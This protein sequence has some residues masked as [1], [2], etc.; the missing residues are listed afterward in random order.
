MASLNVNGVIFA[1]PDTGDEEWG[2][3]ASNWATAVT[4]GMLQKQGGSFTLTAEVDFGSSFG[5]KS[6]YYKSRTSNPGTSGVLRLGNT[7][8]IV[9]RNAANSANLTFGVNSANTLLFDGATIAVDASNVAATQG[10]RIA[11]NDNTD[12]AS[13][14]RLYCLVG[15]S[16]GGD[17][18]I[19]LSVASATDWS[20]GCDNSDSDAIVLN[21]GT[22]PGANDP[23]LRISTAGLVA[24]GATGGTQDHVVNGKL[25]I[26]SA[27]G[28]QI[29]ASS[30]NL[31]I[32]GNCY[33]GSTSGPL[34]IASGTSL[35]V[36]GGFRVGGSSQASAIVEFS[37]TTQGF[38]PPRM[39][40]AQKNAIS[41]PAN[42][43]IV[44][45]S[46][47]DQLFLYNGTWKQVT[48]T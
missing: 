30:T 16:S 4:N 11:N 36:D 9:W 2:S 39:S 35:R 38:L 31:V 42:G 25:R 26:G 43:L 17:P 10:I 27:S 13:N 33:V 8:L 23:F 41:S 44:Y 47:L 19:R 48:V 28:P 45:D 32:S 46:T 3:A 1:Y 20:F 18:F 21:S 40:T 15:G 24:I 29:A 12:T 7:D 22:T 34:L 5:L 37:S 6:L 14:A